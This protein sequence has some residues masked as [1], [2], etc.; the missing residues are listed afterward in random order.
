MKR[1]GFERH[2]FR[3]VG[4]LQVPVLVPGWLATAAA[5]VFCTY[6][7]VAIDRGSHSLSDT[8]Y[9]LFPYAVSAFLLWDWLAQRTCGTAGSRA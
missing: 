1:H 8:P 3:R 6:L 5:L 4:W 7:M 2:W 9:G